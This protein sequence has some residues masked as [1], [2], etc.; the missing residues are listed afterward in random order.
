MTTSIHARL[1]TAAGVVMLCFFGLTGWTL[2][3]IYRH[4]AE[5]ALQDR[6][7]SDAY[8]IIAA[9]EIDERGVLK[10][11]YLLP[12]ARFLTPSSSV[13]GQIRSKG[14]RQLWQSA[15]LSQTRIDFPH[16]LARL[17]RRFD[18]LTTSTGQ[19]VYAFSLGVAWESLNARGEEFTVSVA[20]N[21]HEFEQK[22][23]RFQRSLWSWLGGVALLLIAAQS[24]ILR[25]GL[26]P[27]KRV[28][29]EL[30]WIERGDRTEISADIPRELKTL[31]RNLN[32]LLR[33]RH[34]LIERTRNSL[35][36][37]AHSL[38]TPL[39]VLRGIVEADGTRSFDRETVRE[40]V[41]S[42][43]RIVGYQLQKGAAVG[44]AALAAPLHIRTLC[45][46]I[47]ATLKKVYADKR[48]QTI[49][50][51]SDDVNYPADEG[52]LMELLGN[53][54]DNANKWCVERIDVSVSHA[55]DDGSSVLRI[56]IGD[57][58]PGIPNELIDAVLQRGGRADQR[59][60]GHGIG[61]A[62]VR[63]IVKLYQGTLHITRHPLGGAQIQIDLPYP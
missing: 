22:I 21:L 20:S 26:A 49:V 11:S 16:D 28:A 51:I 55:R 13:Y 39:A 40:Q 24:L 60:D 36:D 50:N 63:D 18:Y 45:E 1:I 25:W 27:L 34:D 37:L 8:A 53:L 19:P 9:A 2:Q 15:S 56:V 10:L 17:E 3:S 14:G 58:G 23:R 7:Q 42:M 46:K 32:A 38:K 62:V 33:N 5:T 48:I 29:D 30:T 31:T 35:G 12:D 4:D 57:D 44:R 43:S 41:D 52:D 59:T 54:L 47:V 61:L 6:L